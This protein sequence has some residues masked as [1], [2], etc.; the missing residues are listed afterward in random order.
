MNKSPEKKKKRLMLSNCKSEST[1]SSCRLLDLVPL[2]H[3]IAE[4]TTAKE[5]LAL[6]QEIA[7]E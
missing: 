3:S 2:K 1:K 5:T 6:I 4:S 7:H